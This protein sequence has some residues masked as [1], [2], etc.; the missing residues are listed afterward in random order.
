[1]RARRRDRRQR[2][3]RRSEGAIRPP[4][5]RH[6][7]R[8]SRPQRLPRPSMR[9]KRRGGRA[10]RWRLRLPVA[11]RSAPF[12]R[13]P[14]ARATPARR[15]ALRRRGRGSRSSTTAETTRRARLAPSAVRIAASRMRSTVRVSDRF[16]RFAHA[17]RRTAEMAASSSHSPA[18]ARPT[19]LS[20]SGVIVLESVTGSCASP[21]ARTLTCR[22]RTFSSATASAIVTPS[23]S[24]ASAWLL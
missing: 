11:D 3:H 23:R 1:M 14:S 20:A 15:R 7:R 2:P 16:A 19:M 13:T 17:I 6:A 9:R 10:C 5:R 18:R 8:A 21:A 24:R 12:G 4:S 22:W